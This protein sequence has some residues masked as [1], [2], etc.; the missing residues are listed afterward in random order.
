M[1]WVDGQAF[2][3][4]DQWECFLSGFHAVGFSDDHAALSADL[5][6]SPDLLVERSFDVLETWPITSAVHISQRRNHRAWMGHAACFLSHGAGAA[7]SVAAYW[8]LS[9]K[10]RGVANSCVMQAVN[11]WIK[12]NENNS[13][14]GKCRAASEQLEFPYSRLRR[15]A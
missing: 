1:K 4:Y 11:H 7:S 5:Y 2:A 8:M 14:P 15:S 9:S 3:P 10:G 6:R 12:R 13:R